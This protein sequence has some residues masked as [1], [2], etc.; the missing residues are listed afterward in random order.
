MMLDNPKWPQDHDEIEAFLTVFGYA[1]CDMSK[2][3]IW[4]R[5][6]YRRDEMRKQ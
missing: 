1:D 4:A 6:E 5:W 2:D 3:D